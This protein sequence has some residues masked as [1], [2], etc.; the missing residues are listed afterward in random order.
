MLTL[1]ELARALLAPVLVAAAMA[2]VGAWRRWAWLLPVAA[3]AGFLTGFALFG[4]PRLPPRDGTDWLFWLALPLTAAG[5]TDAVLQHRPA[6]RRYGWLAGAVMGATAFVIVR[7]LVPA[8]VSTGT[9]IT[10][11][12]ALAAAG[13]ALVLAAGWAEPRVGAWAVVTAFCVAVGGV[14]VVVMSSHLRIVGIYGIA[15]SAALGPVAVGAGRFRDADRPGRAVAVVAVGLLAGL[16]AGGRY[17]PD[18]GVSWVNFVVL[19]AAPALLL[20]GALLP[21]KRAWVRGAAAVLAV[22]LAVGAVT[23]PTAL[24]AKRAAEAESSEDPYSGYYQ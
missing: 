23:V 4:V 2:A 7:P 22:A 14:G 10:L 21:V 17:Y 8:S 19:V 24:E 3:G 20:L 6:W 1:D 9:L 12:P 18:P 13:A 16:L 11:A 5:V 15:A